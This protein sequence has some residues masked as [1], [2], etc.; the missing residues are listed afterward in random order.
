MDQV[1]RRAV[2]HRAQGTARTGTHDH[3]VGQERTAGD[4]RHKI[5]IVVIVDLALLATA[6]R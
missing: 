6:K 1:G 4:R 3:A 2:N 5:L